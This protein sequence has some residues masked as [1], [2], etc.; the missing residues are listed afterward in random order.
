[1]IEINRILCAVDLSEPSKAALR[2]AESM[3]TAMSAELIVVHVIESQ[4]YPMAYGA[5]AVAYINFEEEAR[6][7][8]LEALEP[9]V[10]AIVERGV[11]ASALVETGMAWVRVCELADE[12]KADLVVVATHGW[13]G[14]KHALIGSTAE[15]IVRKCKCPVLS[16]K[17][18]SDG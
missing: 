9:M 15:R 7:A 14:I 8:A 1:M 6:K 12:L 2:H 5:P 17:I 13:T 3:A 10:A 18:E 11:K 4:I 16:V